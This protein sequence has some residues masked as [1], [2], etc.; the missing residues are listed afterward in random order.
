M[1]GDMII[2]TR[3][4]YQVLTV[5]DLFQ[6]QYGDSGI[7]SAHSKVGQDVGICHLSANASKLRSPSPQGHDEVAPPPTPFPLCW[8]QTDFKTWTFSLPTDE[9]PEGAQIVPSTFY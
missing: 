2:R 3:L 7:S 1:V 4:R 6:V 9:I 8:G 5:D